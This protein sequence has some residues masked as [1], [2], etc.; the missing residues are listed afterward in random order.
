MHWREII[1]RPVVT[2]KSSYQAT[3]LRQYVFVVNAKANKIQIKHAIENAFDVTVGKVRVANMP[4]K[5]GRSNRTRRMRI[6]KSAYKKAVV[7][8]DE[9]S[10]ALFEGVG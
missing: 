7:T 9:G 4:A 5:L 10:I 2:E 3:Q 8:L 6:R 1:R